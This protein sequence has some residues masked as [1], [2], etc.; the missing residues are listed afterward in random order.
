MVN[1]QG[2]L[3]EIFE[4]EIVSYTFDILGNKLEMDL[5]LLDGGEK[6]N[7]HLEI[8]GIS[9]Y[10]YV[11]NN[12]EIRKVFSEKEEDDY[13]EL[14]SI[15]LLQEF[16]DINIVSKNSKWLEQYSSKGNLVIELWDKLLILEM[17]TI[18][19]DD[20]KFE[21]VESDTLNFGF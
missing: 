3:N 8:L 9:A 14:T 19:L 6:Q 20:Y 4:S 17:T 13:L 7:F 10:Y 1:I 12:G 16:V 5:S 11:N 21:L 15:T 18:I 2:K